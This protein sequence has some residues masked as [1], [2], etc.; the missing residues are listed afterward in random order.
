[1][2]RPTL[3]LRHAVAALAVLVV[4]ASLAACGRD[5]KV[6]NP[7]VTGPVTWTNTVSHLLADR[8]E[9]T[10][11]TGCTSCHHAGTGI[12]DW[13]NYATVFAF[14]STIRARIQPGG[15]MDQFLKPGEHAIVIG[16]ID[17]GAPE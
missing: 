17:A 10:A 3:E 14:R 4:I 8:S 7:P 13:S 9:G 16:W 15:I 11:P 2:T 5:D 6:L 1:M 12:P